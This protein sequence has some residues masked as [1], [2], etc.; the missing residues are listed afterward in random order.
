MHFGFRVCRQRRF[1]LPM[2]RSTLQLVRQYCWYST[3]C[4]WSGMSENR[5]TF[6]NNRL[7]CFD[8]LKNSREMGGEKSTLL[9]FTDAFT[10]LQMASLH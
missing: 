7:P 6:V 9:L 10:N 2:S 8:G 5:K 4:P 3:C 1:D